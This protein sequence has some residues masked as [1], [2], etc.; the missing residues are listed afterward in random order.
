[1]VECKAQY[2]ANSGLPLEDWVLARLERVSSLA[3]HF[4]TVANWAI[5]NRATRWLLE[6]TLGV[7][8]ERKL[9]RVASRTF[10]R[11]AHR[12]RL[13][14][15]PRHS[16]RK[17][18][19]FTD[20]YANWYDTQLAEAFVRIL[21]H[22]GIA[23]YVHPDQ[24]PSGMAAV[25]MGAL[26]IARQLAYRNVRLLA[27]AVRQGFHIVTTEPAAA[28]CLTHEY[29]NLQ[30]SDEARLVAANTFEAC[31]Y[32]T[33]LH[34]SGKLELDLSPVNMVLGY[35][36]PCH[37]R[38]L[39]TG[40][41]GLNLLR[42]IPGALTT[43]LEEGCSGMA[44][45]FGLKRK[46]YRNSLRAGWGLITALRNPSLQFGTT[47]CSACKIQMEQGTGKPT[48]HPLK[49]LALAYGRMPDVA[50]LLTAQCEDLVV[51]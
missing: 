30:D 7:A 8:R 34:Q 41:S 19:Y 10:M 44:G 17:V 15:P 47:E 31:T 9:P 42:L 14:R 45:T 11:W 51:T 1:M 16:S 26:H 48:I 3:S 39:G 49:F 21:Q 36:Q 33:K 25:S 23:V 5:G 35:H 46:N 28:V 24:V 38:V 13:T 43:E 6:K 40:S 37:M 50:H 2:V 4:A 12:R 18:L 29:L 32:L 27:E 20:I 22:N